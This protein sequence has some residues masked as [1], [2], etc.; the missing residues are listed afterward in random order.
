M[1]RI[2]KGSDMAKLEV[3]IRT[4]TEADAPDVAQVH[5]ASWRDAYRGVIPDAAIDARTVE[6]AT[7]MWL[8]N[9]GRFP[10]NLTVAELPDGQIAGFSCAAPSPT[11]ST[12][13]PT[14]SRS[15]PCMSGL[16]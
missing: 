13:P 11:P 6:G 1:R 7:E 5:M 15:T 2:D 3:L 10:E 12:A 8:A 14:N 16:M 4:A 9:L